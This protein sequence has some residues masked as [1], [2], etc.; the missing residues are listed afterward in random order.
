MVDFNSLLP[1]HQPVELPSRG[2]LYSNPALKDGWIHIREY[3]APEESLIA[4]M[5]KENIQQVIN[6]LLDS[7]IKGDGIKAE[8]LTSEDALYL[9]YWLRANSYG[10]MYDIEVTCPH[11]DCGF[12]PD[13]H[14]V[15]LSMLKVNYFDNEVEEPLVLT[16]PKT[17]LQV[18]IMCLRRSMEIKAAKRVPVVLQWRNYRGDPTDLLKRAYS[19]SKVIAS[20]G[21]EITNRLDIEKLCLQILP[22]S[23]SLYIDKHL[24]KFLHGV[25]VRTEVTC[26]QC[27]RTIYTI[28]P[29]GPEF[30]RPTRYDLESEGP[31]VNG[32]NGPEQVWE[33]GRNVSQDMLTEGEENTP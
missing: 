13:T 11:R 4:Q 21:Q 15:N 17:K 32:D 22:S 24:E 23:D 9:L 33:H 6:S 31:P 7:C 19:I 27:E 29:P 20:D 18:H 25:D 12:G 5:N 30:F 26:R 14:T 1:P 28:V 10:P 2:K 16:L 3:C 8:E